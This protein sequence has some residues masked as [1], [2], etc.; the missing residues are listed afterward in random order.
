MQKEIWKY[1]AFPYF[2]K[3]AIRRLSL[4]LIFIHFFSSDIYSQE[5]S[6]KLNFNT[7]ADLYSRYV[8]RGLSFSES[9]NIQP[10]MELSWKGF[11]LMTWGSYALAD[12]Y[13]EIDLFLS[14]STGGFTLNI[15]DYFSED[16]SDFS[17]TSY[18]EWRDTLTNHLVE[19]SAV[20]QLP[21]EKFPISLTASVFLYGA[22]LDENNNQNYSTYFEL[23]C[24]FILKNHECS[25]FLGATA[26]SGYYAD[27]AGIVNLGLSAVR[28]IIIT[29]N[30][31][32]PFS[33]SII[34]HPY[35]NDVFFIA[36]ISF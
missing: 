28:D 5:E 11:S 3:S 18:K 35:N 26:K 23:S 29:D 16:E 10:Y 33:T 25:V 7:G 30:F 20:Y 8:W 27:G 2:V 22:D 12:K 19:A 34:F 32:V 21:I 1:I 31:S 13:A 14:Y 17:A 15:F 24:P 6:S 36:G 4:F 9:P